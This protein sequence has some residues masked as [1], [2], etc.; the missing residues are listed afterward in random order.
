MLLQA[1]YVLP[2][3]GKYR[4]EA[5]Y[6]G[7]LTDLTTNYSVENLDNGLW[8]NDPKYTNTLQYKEKVNAVYTQFGSKIDKFSYLV[9][10]RYEDSNIEINQFTQNIFNNKKYSNLFPSA[11]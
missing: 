4:L 5:G 7:N 11:F 3:A 8:L 9:G 10:L 2:I 6:R 1:D